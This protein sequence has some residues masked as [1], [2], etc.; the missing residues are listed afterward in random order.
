MVA[1]SAAVRRGGQAAPTEF[2]YG[3]T[4]DIAATGQAHQPHD[5]ADHRWV[6][7][8]VGRRAG[9]RHLAL[10]LGTDTGA[11]V[12]TPAALCGVVSLKP[13]RARLPTAGV[14]PLSETCDHVGL[15]S[16]V[17]SPRL[18]GR[19]VRGG[20]ATSGLQGCRAPESECRPTR[21]GRPPTR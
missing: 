7:V 1:R 2:A 3:P 20:R 16:D 9:G 19:A 4:G 8:G 21:T 12:R 18:A 10:T 17:D 6:V 14:F 13:T 15:T 5:Q 11:S